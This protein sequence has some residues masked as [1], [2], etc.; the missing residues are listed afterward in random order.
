MTLC[1]VTIWCAQV[2]FLFSPFLLIWQL[3]CCW[4]RL[5]AG[6]MVAVVTLPQ[7]H[8][9]SDWLDMRTFRRRSEGFSWKTASPAGR[10]GKQ[11]GREDGVEEKRRKVA[12]SWHVRRKGSVRKRERQKRE[13]KFLDM[14]KKNPF[15]PPNQ[16]LY[17]FLPSFP[18][19]NTRRTKFSS[20]FRSSLSLLLLSKWRSQFH[21]GT[22]LSLSLCS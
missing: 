7:P 2:F 1:R 11:E 5:N 21:K 9:G 18:V 4:G 6:W 16:I 15:S 12:T 13:K 10:E 19:Y 20:I 17:F 14:L 22:H 8:W 3:I